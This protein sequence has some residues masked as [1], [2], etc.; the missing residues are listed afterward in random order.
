MRKSPR[1][2]HR[3]SAGS[4]DRSIHRQCRRL[5]YSFVLRANQIVDL[6][7]APPSSLLLGVLS[8]PSLTALTSNALSKSSRAM[9]KHPRILATAGLIRTVTLSFKKP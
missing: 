4:L 1:A 5:S 3:N 7:R 9:D 2:R 8:K 6:S